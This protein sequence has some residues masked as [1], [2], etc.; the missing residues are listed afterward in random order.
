MEKTQTFEN[1]HLVP[2]GLLELNEYLTRP[3]GIFDE[4]HVAEFELTAPGNAQWE[5]TAFIDFLAEY[6]PLLDAH[7][8]RRRPGF[9]VIMI[10][11]ADSNA[12]SSRITVMAQDSRTIDDIFNIIEKYRA[13]SLFFP[14]ILREFSPHP[15][16]DRAVRKTQTIK[17]LHLVRQG[18]KELDEYL[19]CQGG[20]F[21]D[22]HSSM[23]EIVYPDG[24]RR[25]FDKS[26]AFLAE[27]F[28]TF[29]TRYQ[30]SRPGFEISIENTASFR[31]LYSTVTVLAQDRQ[32]IH[33]IFDIIEKYHTQS[34][35]FPAD[36][37]ESA[38]NLYNS[39]RR[40]RIPAQPEIKL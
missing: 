40:D 9:Q 16:K 7:Y 5:F 39:L 1:M 22:P 32:T 21:G 27:Y 4:P 23:F 12:I 26:P 33:E 31:D 6:E 10:N 15:K 37:K 34:V 29:F 36:P 17:H 11:I 18:L 2:E 35:F 19:T 24:A 8:E 20:I 13:V 3:G 25:E 28:P 30:R 38:K 14:Q